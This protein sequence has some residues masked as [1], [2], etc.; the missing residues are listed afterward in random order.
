MCDACVEWDGR[1]WH[2]RPSGYFV[3]RLL[4]HR[5]VWE[6]A[7]GPIPE[8][9]Q[10]H[11]LNGNKGDNRLENLALLSHS[12]HSALHCVEK[13]AP[14][15][16][17]ARASLIATNKRLRE[18]RMQRD[19]VCVV[20]GSVFHSGAKHPTRFCSSRCVQRARSGAFD[21]EQR[22]CEYCGAEYHATRRV[23][24][25]C[26]RRC[27]HL[28]VEARMGSHQERDVACAQRGKVFRSARSNA[29]FCGRPCALAFH[30]NNRFRGKISEAV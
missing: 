15:R 28:A 16:D 27:N 22:K 19:L 9:Y 26:S 7:N 24:R 4:L 8:G 21:G 13:T 18:E 3:A 5:E 30:G 1:T 10:I 25:F 2:R 6:A 29:R 12:E 14:Y 11:H 17:K 20:C 23:Q